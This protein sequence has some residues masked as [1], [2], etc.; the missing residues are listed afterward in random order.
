MN[1]NGLYCILS[2]G[3]STDV[4]K[5][6]LLTSTIINNSIILKTTFECKINKWQINEL[7]V[8]TTKSSITIIKYKSLNTQFTDTS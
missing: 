8:K 4:H 2:R 6:L 5:L 3:T 1:G 7:L